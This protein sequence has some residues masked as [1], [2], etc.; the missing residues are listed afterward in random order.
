MDWALLICCHCSVDKQKMFCT[1][2]KIVASAL[3][4]VARIK[5]SPS[6]KA[7]AMII[8]TGTVLSRRRFV[9]AWT[10]WPVCH[11]RLKYTKKINKKYKCK[12]ALE[13]IQLCLDK[14]FEVIL[15]AI[16]RLQQDDE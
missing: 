1:T 14:L 10:P 15:D 16:L 7:K 9:V 11:A 13:T 3:P 4:R 12:R 2:S 8:I 5:S 6:I